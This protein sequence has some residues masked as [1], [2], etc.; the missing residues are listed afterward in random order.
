MT[1]VKLQIGTLRP[2]RGMAWTETFSVL[3][4]AGNKPDNVVTCQYVLY[5]RTNN[6]KIYASNASIT[7][8]EFTPT[9]PAGYM[10]PATDKLYLDLWWVLNDGTMQLFGQYMMLVQDVPSTATSTPATTTAPQP[11]LFYSAGLA[12]AGARLGPCVFDPAQ[13]GGSGT[14]TLPVAGCGKAPTGAGLKVTLRA[15]GTSTAYTWTIANGSTRATGTDVIAVAAGTTY[16]IYVNTI[17]S[18]FSGEDAY[19]AFLFTPSA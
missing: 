13:Y 3:D 14:L 11:V 1:D 19:V 17:G 18:T 4:A 15:A 2:A 12:V 5:W 8:N 6:G 9:V 7:A 16:D 10:S